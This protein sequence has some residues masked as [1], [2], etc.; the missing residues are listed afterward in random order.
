MN[1]QTK[2]IIFGI[3]TMVIVVIGVKTFPS[4]ASQDNKYSDAELTFSEMK[5]DFGDISMSEGIATKEISFSN[6]SSS[7]VTIVRLETSCMCTST[8]IVHSDGSKSG[9]KG[10]V[11]HGGGSSALSEVIEAGETATLLVN[12]DPNAHGPNATGP[13]TREVILGT[14]S[15]S[16]SEIQIKFSGNVI[17]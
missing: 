16:Q 9:L 8:Q 2:Y 5:W 11:G 10:M 1:K 4:S 7:S 14:N 3:I 6:D 15:Q 13:I 17:K 12:F